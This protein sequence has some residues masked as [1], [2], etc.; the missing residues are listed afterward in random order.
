MFRNSVRASENSNCLEFDPNSHLGLLEL[1]HGLCVVDD[2]DDE[3]EIESAICVMENYDDSSFKDE[4][5]YYICGVIVRRMEKQIKC[6]DCCY[7]LHANDSDLRTY[8]RLTDFKSKGKLIRSSED[9][10]K[11][12]KYAYLLKLSETNLTTVNL[13]MRVCN[14]LTGSVFKGHLSNDEFTGSHELLL[15]KICNSIVFENNISSHCKTKNLACD[16]EI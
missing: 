6:K 15:I 7:V 11:V 14:H 3:S 4:I 8:T 12:V 9:V 5:L 10:L 16:E 13:T 1:G 2:I